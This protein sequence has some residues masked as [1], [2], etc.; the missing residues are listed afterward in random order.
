MSDRLEICA[1]ISIRQ[2]RICRVG[3]IRS[4][5]AFGTSNSLHVIE[6]GASLCNREI[7]AT[8]LAIDMRALGS[9]T[10]GAVPD[11]K[12]GRAA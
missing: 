3:R 12:P 7:I 2:Y 8:V 9:L 11:I 5:N 6:S 1:C 4:C 10:D